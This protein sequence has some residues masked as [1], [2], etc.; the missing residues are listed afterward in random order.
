L[1]DEIEKHVLQE[2]TD[3]REAQI[4]NANQATSNQPWLMQGASTYISG[5]LSRIPDPLN[6]VKVEIEERR[7]KKT[8]N[9]AADREAGEPLIFVSCGQSTSLER[10]LGQSIA[11][12]IEDIT[13]CEAYFAQNQTTFE[14][15]TENILKRLGRAVGFIAIM[16]PRG[17]V[18]NPAD[19]NEAAWTRA[20]VW[21]EQEIA[22]AAFISQAL[23]SPLRVRM[24][25]H[26]NIRREGLRDKLHLNPES[27]RQDSEIIA[28]LERILPSWANLKRQKPRPEPLS[29]S[30]IISSRR[31][32][33]PGG[34]EDQR[35]MLSVG[36]E[37]DGDL[38]AMD[39]KLDVE[40]P[41]GL[42]DESVHMARIASGK[43]GIAIFTNSSEQTRIKHLYPTQRIN[44]VISFHYA[45]RAS[46][47][48]DHP[49][50]L[51]QQVRA[52]VCSGSMK[53]KVTSKTIAQLS[54]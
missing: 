6:S 30:P 5:E 49:E 46:Q 40:F 31:V 28:D 21:I 44:D 27:F 22:I 19:L 4:R 45:I 11:G 25:V 17:N 3:L 39:F 23:E 51:Q 41:E 1:D 42:L 37:N 32:P 13:G 54:N 26:E 14:G 48:R 2:M 8:N 12:L 53:P 29:I 20:S 43:P 38:A 24:Y 52:I 15:V 50:L 33:V 34:G 10:Q 7:H 16:H 36:L 35:Y 47:R 9:W 18:T